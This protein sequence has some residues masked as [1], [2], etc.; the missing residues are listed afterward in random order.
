MAS[1]DGGARSRFQLIWVGGAIALIAIGLGLAFFRGSFRSSPPAG[2]RVAVPLPPP[3]GGAKAMLLVPA[4]DP[5]LVE[6]TPN[7]PLPVIS[8][9]GRQS[10]QVY[11]RP[12]DAKDTRPRIAII[13][14]GIGL[15]QTLSQAAL[16]RLP[17]AVTFGFDPYAAAVKPALANARNLGHEALLGMPMEPLDYPR[18]DPGPL[19]LLTSLDATQN[20]ARLARLMGEATGYVGM[21]AIL[22]SRF[23]VE[24]QSLIPVLETLKQRGLMFADDKPPEQSTAAQL[25]TQMKLPWAAGDHVIDAESDPG[26]IDQALADLETRARA[27]GAALGIAAL[28]P[29]LLDHLGAWLKTLDGKGITLAPASAVANRQSPAQPSP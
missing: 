20:G 22:G 1:E 4:P 7:G 11:A 23:E 25:A 14:T 3:P 5:G 17:G 10:W 19:T 27:R 16:D 12:F 24:T 2:E 15:D 8:K 9:D 28:S 6:D 21:V 29:A 18:Q 26:S 13:V